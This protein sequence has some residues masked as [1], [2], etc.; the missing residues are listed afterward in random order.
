MTQKHTTGPWRTGDRFTTIFGP[1]DGNPIPLV[2]A[3]L[4]ASHPANARLLAAAPEMLEALRRAFN[5]IKESGFSNGLM[6]DEF[7]A[8]LKQIDAAIAKVEGRRP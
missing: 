2:I 1:P 6:E 7:D 8:T 5:L 4:G 3:G